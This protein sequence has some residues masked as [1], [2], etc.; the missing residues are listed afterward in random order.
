MNALKK[1]FLKLLEEDVEFKYTVA[2]YL[3]LSEV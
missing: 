3:G 1:R 2:G